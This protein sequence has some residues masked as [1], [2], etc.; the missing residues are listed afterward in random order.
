MNAFSKSAGLLIRHH[1][2]IAPVAHSISGVKRL[3]S[4]WSASIRAHDTERP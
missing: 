4:N 3:R 2:T 1:F